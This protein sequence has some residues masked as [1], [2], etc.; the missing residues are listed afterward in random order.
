MHGLKR[1][2]RCHWHYSSSWPPLFLISISHSMY[3]YNNNI[4][5]AVPGLTFHFYLLI[6][7]TTEEGKNCVLFI[8]MGE[9]NNTKLGNGVSDPFLRFWELE[10]CNTRKS[11]SWWM[12]LNTWEYIWNRDIS[13]NGITNIIGF[14]KFFFM[15]YDIKYIISTKPRYIWDSSKYSFLQWA[16]IVN[17]HGLK[18]PRY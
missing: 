18:Y 13:T 2:Q 1:K 7:L 10:L 9:E 3:I 8:I 4:N 11:F 14:L 12:I 17:C 15:K 16:L 6:P 5:L